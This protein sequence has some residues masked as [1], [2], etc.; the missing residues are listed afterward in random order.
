M[1]RENEAGQCPVGRTLFARGCLHCRE[2]GGRKTAPLQMPLIPFIFCFI[3]L[4]VFFGSFFSK[5]EQTIP[6]PQTPV[7]TTAPATDRQWGRKR[8]YHGVSGFSVTPVK[9]RRHAAYA[10]W[11]DTQARDPLAAQIE[12]TRRGGDFGV[13]FLR[14]GVVGLAGLDSTAPRRGADGAQHPAPLFQYNPALASKLGVAVGGK[15]PVGVV[16]RGG[17]PPASA[18]IGSK[19]QW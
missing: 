13:D 14:L 1:T 10:V 2:A 9:K 18:G 4:K 7:Q 15:I 3:M 12:R 8:R 16:I 6:Q 11:V 19:L 5:K 17:P